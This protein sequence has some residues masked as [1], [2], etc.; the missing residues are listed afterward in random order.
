MGLEFNYQEE[1]AKAVDAWA[2]G[3]WEWGVPIT[4][5]A[6]EAA[7]SGDWGLLLTPKKFVPKEWYAPYLNGNSF[8][9]VKVLGLA[10]GGGQQM[11]I[12]AGLGADTTVLDYSPAQLESERIVSEREGY[13]I[14]IIRADM[15]K[16]LPFEDNS[17]D[18]IFHP[19]SNC[20]V[21]DV[22]HVWREAYRVLKRGGVLLAGFDYGVSYMFDEENPF[23]A[24]NK[25]PFNPLKDPAL[26]EKLKNTNS[27]IQFSHTI[28]EQIGGQLLA[29]FA[30]T[31]LF[32][33]TD[34]YD[35]GTL[36]PMYG[37][38]RAVKI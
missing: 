7:L 19:V 23:L 5:K 36:M 16:T 25:L 8:K 2:K 28:E 35:I 12:F 27:G 4:R 1:N 37:A 24:V 21:E 26:Y 18:L 11:P 9:G 22:Y 6:Y 20:Y 30:L 14:D 29:G 34:D 17:F 3:G 15:T 13:K 31:H 33:D 38:T 10:S 32:E